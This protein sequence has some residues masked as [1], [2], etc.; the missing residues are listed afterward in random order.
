MGCSVRSAES[1]ARGNCCRYHPRKL[2]IQY[3]SAAM[4]WEIV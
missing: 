2:V 1:T 3:S 4:N